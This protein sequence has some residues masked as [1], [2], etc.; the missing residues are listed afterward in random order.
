MDTSWMKNY[1]LA[2]EI[3]EE[4]LDDNSSLKKILSLIENN[5]RVVDFGC[6]TGYLAKLLHR[7]GCTVTGVEIN[8]DAAKIAEKYC[9]KVIIVDLDFVSVTKIL[10]KEEFDVAVFG[11]VLEHLRNPWKVLKETQQI[12]KKDGFVVASIPNIAHGAIRLAL[13]QGQFEYNEYGILDNTHLRFFT[14]KTINNLFEKSGYTIEVIDRTKLSIFSSS[15]YIP[16]IHRKDFGNEVIQHIQHDEN[17]DTLQFVVKAV[18]S[19]FAKVAP[20][21]TQK[22]EIGNFL[23]EA[24]PDTEEEIL[25]TQLEQTQTE[26]KRSNFYLEEA[27]QNIKIERMQL[28]LKLQEAEV[29]I[30]QNNFY[31]QKIIENI[32]T[33]REQFKS[34]LSQTLTELENSQFYLHETFQNIQQERE[35]YRLQI[36]HLQVRFDQINNEGIKGVSLRLLKK[37][38]AKAKRIISLVKSDGLKALLHKA[39]NKFL[40]VKKVP[41]VLINDKTLLGLS[42]INQ[43]KFWEILNPIIQKSLANLQEGTPQISIL[44]PTWNSSLDWFVETAASVFNQTLPNWE[45]CIVDDGSKNQEI[46]T[47]VQELARKHPRVKVILPEIGGGISSATNL[48]LEL[49]S[50]EFVCFLDHDDTLVPTAIEEFTQKL[51][52]GFDVVYSDEDKIDISGLYYTEIFYKPDWSPEYFRGVMYVGHLL[53]VRKELAVSVGGLK[54]EFNGVQDYELMLRISEA[55]NKIAHIPKILYHWRK[56]PGSIAVDVN[57]KAGI[58]KLQQAA[59]N[60]HLER[61]NLAAKAESGKG[62]HRVKLVS[63][64]RIHYPLI[65][66]IIPTK[67]AP[68]YLGKCLK[69]IFSL[70]SYPNYEVILV[71]NETTDPTALQIMSEYPVKRVPLPNPFNFSRANNLGVKSASGDYIVCLNNDTELVSPDWLENL[72]YYAEQPDIGVVG[73]LLLYPDKTVQHAGIVMGFRGTA[74]HVMRGF[75]CDV[76]GYAGSLACARE[77]SAVTAACLIVKKSDFEAVG[78]FNEH[79]FTHYQDVDFCLQLVKRGK[80]NIYTPNVV[81]IH[82]ESKTRKNYYDMVDRILLLDLHQQYID[83]G[84][85]YYNP[86]FD[87]AHYDYTIRT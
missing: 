34:Q 24:I 63:N 71:D 64:V 26:L 69:S 37:I 80:R 32:E 18:V 79:F 29:K 17:A 50:G 25:R 52:E 7:K 70:T 66:I 53:C 33:E 87:I 14:R 22:I 12:L 57:A 5:K 86:N 11:D 72:L 13:L 78:G 16:E 3:I 81:L 65:S 31:L 4:T 39:K 43:E 59:V 27:F 67:D 85:P 8:P 49:S 6:A 44:T 19:D 10:A 68:D 84:D 35:Q 58:E 41:L 23:P 20:I 21:S 47:V 42:G 36:Q 60:A 54:S 61:L 45:W 55:T 82:Y 62:N 75:P 2:E 46:R 76:D 9:Q 51:A 30:E 28:E 73:S 15:P 83:L 38:K 77:V 74:D 1:P 48:A 40:P 56:I